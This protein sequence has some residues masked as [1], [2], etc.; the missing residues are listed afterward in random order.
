MGFGEGPGASLTTDELDRVAE[1]FG[2]LALVEVGGACLA[3]LAVGSAVAPH[4][5]DLA[6][7]VVDLASQVSQ[8]GLPEVACGPLDLA[9]LEG[10]S[11]ASPYKWWPG[12]S[13]RTRS[14]VTTTLK[15]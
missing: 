8:Q 7:E 1:V 4:G 11:S 12:S 6:T 10:C 14:A 13:P 9:F 15:R 3:A 5:L 2:G